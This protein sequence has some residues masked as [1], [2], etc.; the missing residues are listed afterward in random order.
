MKVRDILNAKGSDVATIAADRTIADVLRQIVERKVG[1]LVVVDKSGFPVGIITERDLIRLAHDKGEGN[2]RHLSVDQVMTKNII[3]GLPD[4][5]IEYIMKLM[6]A[7]RFRHVPIM[8]AG[9]LAGIVSIGDVIKS[10]LS[11]LETDN[12]YL[13]DYIAN[14]YPC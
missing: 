11:D 6:T 12:R 14:K 3:I 10:H 2:W 9:K 7:N 5:D 13:T 8:K 1:S 4:D